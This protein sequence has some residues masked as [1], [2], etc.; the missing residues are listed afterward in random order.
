MKL[1]RYGPAGKEKPGLVD[2][3][4]NIRDLSQGERRSTTRCSRRATSRSSRA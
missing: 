4:G 1:L 2:T 3:D